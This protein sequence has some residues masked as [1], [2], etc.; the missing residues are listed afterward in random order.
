MRKDGKERK[1]FV[2]VLEELGVGGCGM[3]VKNFCGVIGNVGDE[4]DFVV[5]VG[6]V[7]VRVGGDGSVNMN[8]EGNN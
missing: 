7:M 4:R 5:E 6:I 3:N 8:G 1:G 2:W